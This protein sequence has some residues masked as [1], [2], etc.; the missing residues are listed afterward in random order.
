[1][2]VA[3]P[4]SP[5]SSRTHSRVSL[6][7]TQPLPH[8][9]T[10]HTYTPPPFSHSQQYSK[11]MVARARAAAPPKARSKCRC[12][13]LDTRPPPHL[14]RFLRPRPAVALLIELL[15]RERGGAWFPCACPPPAETLVLRLAVSAELCG[16]SWPN[17]PE[18]RGLCIY[19]VMA[20]V[21]GPGSTRAPSLPP[22]FGAHVACARLGAVNL[23]PAPVFAPPVTASAHS[24]KMLRA[25][26]Q[27][28]AVLPCACGC[29]RRVRHG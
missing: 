1:M 8:S 10:P 15:C 4:L 26:C 6:F 9:Y 3:P 11:H 19:S 13:C 28:W 24:H 25:L 17:S 22:C 23:G 29:R 18:A 12:V 7:L 16:A 27:P 2:C 20:C 14:P 21:W 5:L